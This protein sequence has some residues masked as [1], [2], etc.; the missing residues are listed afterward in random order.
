LS[1]ELHIPDAVPAPAL[2]LCHGLDAQGYHYLKFYTQFAQEACKAGFVVLVFDFRGVGKSSGNF[3]Y[4]IGEQQDVRCALKYLSSRPEVFGDRLFIVGH[5]L[6]GAVSLYAARDDERIK[7]LVVW[8]TPKNHDYN[9]KKFIRRNRG[10]LGL[11]LFYIFS[12]IDKFVGTSRLF[13]LQVYG[14]QLRPRYVREKLM[15]LNEV[16][17]VSKLNLPVLVV[18]GKDDMIVGVDEA[19]AVFDSA[20]EPK[21]LFVIEGADHNYRGKENE[22]IQK[23]LAWMR[24]V[25]AR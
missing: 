5:S 16:E 9:V 2:L 11:W 4:G 8:S 3:G 10:M 7:G 23:T 21:D 22:L 18:I 19:Q 14:I 1:A 13:K 17:A 15:K 24:K 20:K 6:G 12:I 25:G